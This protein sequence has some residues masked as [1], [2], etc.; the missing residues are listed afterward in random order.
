MRDETSPS[1]TAEQGETSTLSRRTLLKVGTVFGGWAAVALGTGGF[2]SGPDE[3]PSGRRFGY[4]GTPVS[5]ADVA[6]STPTPESTPTTA[7]TPTPTGEV[8]PT[9]TAASTPTPTAPSGGTNRRE[10]APGRETGGDDTA[11]TATVTATYS[12]TG[13]GSQ[14]Y[15]NFGYGGFVE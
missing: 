13:L 8:T 14:G 11:E 15:G 3:T 5:P 6:T 9:P 12:E 1:E 2:L 10:T 7:S 4:G